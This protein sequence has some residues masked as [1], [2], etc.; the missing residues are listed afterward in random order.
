MSPTLILK[1]IAAL[2]T[3]DLDLSHQS[4]DVP[5]LDPHTIGRNDVIYRNSSF[6]DS[7][8]GTSSRQLMKAFIKANT[9][10]F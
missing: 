6:C 2:M 5:L 8:I 9:S 1:L 10:S 3:S 7:I 4:H